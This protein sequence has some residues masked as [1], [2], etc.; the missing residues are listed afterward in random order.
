M[1]INREALQNLDPASRAK[2]EEQLKELAQFYEENPLLSYKPH[3][4]QRK[5]HKSRVRLKAF[6]GGNRSG[7]TTAGINDCLIQAVE[8]SALPPHLLPYKQYEPPFF[9]RIVTPDFKQTLHG[10]IIPKLR[11]WTPRSELKGGSFDKAYRKDDQQLMF[12]NGSWFQFMTHEQ[13]LDKFGGSALHRVLYDEEPPEDIRGECLMRLMDYGGDEVFCFTPL[14][15]MSWA[16]DEIWMKRKQKG[17]FVVQVSID[18]NPAIRAEEKER[19]LSQF[20]PEERRARE[21]G[22]FVHFAGLV[23]PD[24][25]ES[26]NLVDISPDFLVD[27]KTEKNRQWIVCGIDPGLTN[28]GLIWIAFDNDNRAFIFDAIKVREGV[29]EDVANIIRATN[30]KHGLEPDVY[31]IDPNVRVR[32]PINGES[33][34]TAYIRNGILA[35]YG[36]ND[37]D[38]GV[39]QIRTMLRDKTLFVQAGLTDLLY[40][41]S[42]YRVDPK[43]GEKGKFAVIKRNDHLMDAMRYAI[44]S[45]VWPQAEEDDEP[46]ARVYNGGI[47]TYDY[48]GPPRPT[49]PLG[50]MT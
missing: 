34:E 18:D 1:R 7:K 26:K 36:E 8:R 32:S 25:D 6:I 12:A 30:A 40:E 28:T 45:R 41:F 39:S 19:V 16:Y 44:M 38:S 35:I 31:V 13:D 10:V 9:A 21:H 3:A 37:L 48:E 27:P 23:Y 47:S 33:L 24:F 15:G 2:V 22:Q 11:E 17:K 20:T 14:H 4:K 49:H 46:P 42:R 50:P 5:F 43:P 29:V